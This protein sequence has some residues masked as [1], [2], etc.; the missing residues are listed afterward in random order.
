MKHLLI[1]F[2]YIL[3]FSSFPAFGQAISNQWF[4]LDSVG[5]AANS[6]LQ[7]FTPASVSVSNGLTIT[8]ASQSWT[9][10]NADRALATKNYTSGMIIANTNSFTY[11][12]IAYR[13]SFPQSGQGVHSTVWL[14]GENCNLETKIQFGDALGSCPSGTGAAGWDEV[15]MS[16]IMWNT[17][18]N[19]ISRYTHVEGVNTCTGP[20][21]TIDPTQMHNYE[22]DWTSTYVKAYTDGSLYMTCT[23]SQ[24]PTVPLFLLITESVQGSVTATFPTSTQMQYIRVCPTSTATGSCTQ[25][26]ATIFDEE[27]TG[28]GPLSSVYVAQT[29]QGNA[30]GL[31]CAD[32]FGMLNYQQTW[33]PNNAGFWSNGMIGAGTAI[34]LCGPLTTAPTMNGSG[35]RAAPIQFNYQSGASGPCP[36]VGAYSNI[37]ITGQACPKA[38][39]GGSSMMGGNVAVQ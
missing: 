16:E 29:Y 24:V 22:V 34:N 4:V 6:H 21:Y 23:G 26:A 7:C 14:W 20:T 37:S 33:W 25:T 38:A 35:T 10:G 11:G 39:S 19:T 1:L 30:T 5:N 28:S 3:A 36:S 27:W 15:D 17:A 2:L 18:A 13:A 31:D 9:C 8:A 32:A 12:N